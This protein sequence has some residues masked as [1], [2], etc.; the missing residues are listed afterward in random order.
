MRVPRN[1]SSKLQMQVPQRNERCAVVVCNERCA[2]VV[3]VMRHCCCCD[4]PLLCDERCAVGEYRPRT[5]QLHCQGRH[6]AARKGSGS[7]LD[8]VRTNTSTFTYQ[9][10][11]ARTHKHAQAHTHTKQTR[12]RT[13]T[14]THTHMHTHTH[15]H[16]HIPTPTSWYPGASFSLTGAANKK[17]LH[18]LSCITARTASLPRRPQ[19]S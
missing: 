8:Q 18:L 11:H 2:V 15:A 3:V 12:I 1:H 17:P 6:T 13:H 7:P 19:C 9:H 14:H 16:T 5:T 4:A 10:T